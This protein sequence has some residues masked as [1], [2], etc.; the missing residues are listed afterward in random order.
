MVEDLDVAFAF[1]LFVVEV[2]GCCSSG[3]G[4][5]RDSGI[6]ASGIGPL[7]VNSRILA[8]FSFNKILNY[9]KKSDTV[10][11]TKT[12]QETMGRRGRGGTFVRSSI[13]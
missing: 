4:E 3:S 10:H 9:T 12:K 5:L 13:S 6:L 2:V 11:K 8:F 7:F 1:L